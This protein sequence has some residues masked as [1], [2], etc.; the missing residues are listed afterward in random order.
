MNQAIPW[1]VSVAAIL[2]SLYVYYRFKTSG[3]ADAEALNE[4]NVR[5]E[6][7][8]RL[9]QKAEILLRQKE[10]AVSKAKSLD[11]SAAV[12]LANA[13]KLQD[14][15]DRLEAELVKLRTKK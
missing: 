3:A 14:E 9:F 12:H 8:E 13:E 1:L 15:I 7:V 2:C 10:L 5:K 4:E 6:K 11:S